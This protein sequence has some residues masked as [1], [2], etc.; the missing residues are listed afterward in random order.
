M[1]IPEASSNIAYIK[2]EVLECICH[3]MAKP[4]PVLMGFL[5]T[6]TLNIQMCCSC[7][8]QDQCK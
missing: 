6:I 5:F 8:L 1:N 7:L 3:V 4:L 2:D